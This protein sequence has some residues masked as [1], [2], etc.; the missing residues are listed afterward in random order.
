MHK[1]ARERF[2]LRLPTTLFTY[3]QDN[4]NDMG[5]SINALILQV[6]WE[7]TEKKGRKDEGRSVRT[8]GYQ[9]KIQKNK[10]KNS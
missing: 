9:K 7:W 1:D 3:L 8:C 5:T 10:E 6:L 4:A 2:T